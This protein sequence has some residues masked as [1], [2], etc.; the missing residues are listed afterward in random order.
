MTTVATALHSTTMALDSRHRRVLATLSLLLAT[1]VIA[2][3]SIGA[4]SIPFRSVLALLLAFARGE[5]AEMLDRPEMGV[6]LAIRLPRTL[7]GACVGAALSM[8][9]TA[10][11]GLFRNPL[12]DPGLVGVS[13]GA[14]LA[15]AATL[16]LA[17]QFSFLV[18]LAAFAGGLLATLAVSF[19]GVRGG[20]ARVATMLLAGIALNALTA[21]ATGLLLF[22]ATDAQL[23]NVIFWNLGS[24]AAATWKTVLLCL[25]LILGGLIALPRLARPLNAI[26]LGEAEATHLGVDVERVKRQTIIL[27]ALAVG[28]SV[29]VSGVIGFVGLVV[30]HLLRLVVGPDHRILLPG[31][32]LLGASLLLASDL[33][34]RTIAA[35]AELPIGIVTAGIGA[36]FFLWLLWRQRGSLVLS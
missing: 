11:Q 36:P 13:S 2:S 10:L 5:Q 16:V 29:S 12:V 17:E 7:F 9:G 1:C 23:R 27:V 4:M 20:R 25:P 32:A 33:I 35:P 24:V 3:A 30:P 15:A 8:S 18:P 22:L 6:L 34:A 28:A 31:S 21:A 26:L 19:F 14:A